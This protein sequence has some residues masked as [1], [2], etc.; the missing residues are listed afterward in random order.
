MEGCTSPGESPYSPSCGCRNKVRDFPDGAVRSWGSRGIG[1]PWVELES[2]CDGVG[3]EDVVGGAEAAVAEVVAVVA[4]VVLGG[5]GEGDVVE[6]PRDV[7]GV[8]CVDV[9]SFGEVGDEGEVD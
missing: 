1:A 9:L 5:D 2:P 7:A 3:G 8:A 6:R 4:V